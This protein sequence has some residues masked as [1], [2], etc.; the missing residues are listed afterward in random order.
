MAGWF[1]CGHAARLS[2]VAVHVS[3]TVH[4]EPHQLSDLS[5]PMAST[6]TDTTQHDKVRSRL[7]QP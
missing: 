7:T 2:D 1:V 3:M 5:S 4:S 6:L